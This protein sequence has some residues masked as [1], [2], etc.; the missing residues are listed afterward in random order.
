MG[1]DKALLSFAPEVTLAAQVA[2]QVKQ[3]AGSA[4]LLGPVS[5]YGSLG[6]CWEDLRPDQGP[7]GGLETA[8]SRTKAAYNLVVACDLPGLE[9]ATLSQLLVQAMLQNAP[10]TVLR[11]A[12]GRIHPLCG[13]YHPICLGHIQAALDSGDRK[14]MN[15][16][17]HLVPAFFDAPFAVANINR[18]EDWRRF[19]G[20]SAEGGDD[21]GIGATAV[22]GAQSLKY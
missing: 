18:P 21:E 7:L 6:E 9:A 10:C 16:V 17:N 13:V 5:R 1:Q 3:A 19:R 15:V 2:A 12:T 11:D 14:V 22:T 20:A 8:L 4:V